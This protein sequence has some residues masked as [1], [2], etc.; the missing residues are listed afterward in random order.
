MRSEK[1]EV[2]VAPEELSPFVAAAKAEGL[3][4]SAWIRRRVQ[5]AT[6]KHVGKDRQ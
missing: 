4:L 5:S 6:R 3:S 1:I 2:R